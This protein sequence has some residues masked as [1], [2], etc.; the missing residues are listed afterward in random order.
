MN[1]AIIYIQDMEEP[2]KVQVSIEVV[3]E[4]K[5]SYVIAA[6]I[7]DQL[8]EH[9]KVKMVKESDFTKDSPSKWLN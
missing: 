5:H 7:I 2:G 6:C 3:G 8:I 4:P 9:Q 1:A